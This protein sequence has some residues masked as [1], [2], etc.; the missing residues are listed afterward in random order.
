M[1]IHDFNSTTYCYPLYSYY[2]YTTKLHNKY[3]INITLEYY[4]TTPL[5][6]IYTYQD[7]KNVCSVAVTGIY[8]HLILLWS[9]IITSKDS[10]GSILSINSSGSSVGMNGGSTNFCMSNFHC[11]FLNPTWCFIRVYPS[12]HT[13][14]YPYR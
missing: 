5:L 1:Y 3:T 7:W 10:K 8:N 11:T 13:P 4:N 14:T 2:Y 12:C 9:F 6:Y